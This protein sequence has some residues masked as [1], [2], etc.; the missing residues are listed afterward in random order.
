MKITVLASGSAGNCALVEAG[1]TRILVDC[2][3]RLRPLAR[4]L[5]AAG[6][7][8]ES[9]SGVLLTHEHGDHVIG[10]I[11]FSERFGVPLFCSRGT[12]AGLNLDGTLFGHYVAVAGG[13]ELR[14]GD[15]NVRAFS[16]PHDAA[17][18][19][20]FRFEDARSSCVVASD[21]GRCDPAFVEFLS[22]V[23]AMLFEFNHDED[24]LR[25]GPYHWSLKNRI[26]GGYGHLS[27]R[28][29]AQALAASAWSGLR[30][31]V[32]IHLSRQNNDPALVRA[33]LADALVR[34]ECSAEF[35]CADQSDGYEAF[36][37]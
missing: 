14:I 35:G 36:E 16:T 28:Q 37:V 27:N 5:A 30:R 32:A 19:L 3:L 8:P 26:A 18:P 12:A 4:K 34:A 23:Q 21:L 7:D 24:M 13:T 33:A 17:E 15:V 31:V 10:A 9:V 25:E 2:G 29:S 22:G 6:V 11:D 1:R 20:A